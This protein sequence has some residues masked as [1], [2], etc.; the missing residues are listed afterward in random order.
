MPKG[1]PAKTG[2][3]PPTTTIM[4]T[5]GMNSSRREEEQQ[6]PRKRS[7][8]YDAERIS[9]DILAVY[10]NWVPGDPT[11]LLE[12][13]FLRCRSSSPS[14]D[15][16]LLQT[17]STV[18]AST[19]TTKTTV[20]RRGKAGGNNNNNNNKKT[21]VRRRGTAAA[22]GNIINN[23]RNAG[24]DIPEITSGVYA[25]FLDRHGQ[26]TEYFPH[27]MLRRLESE[28]LR[29]L[30]AYASSSA[31]SAPSLSLSSSTSSSSSSPP[32]SASSPASSLSS[33][34]EEHSCTSTITPSRAAVTQGGVGGGQVWLVCQTEK[35][36]YE[37]HF[38]HRPSAVSLST[39]IPIPSSSSDD[40]NSSIRFHGVHGSLDDANVKVME[41]F[42][43][44]HRGFMPTTSSN[45]PSY[46][47]SSK[48]TD[49]GFGYPG[50]NHGGGGGGG[51]DINNCLGFLEMDYQCG[52]G[53]NHDIRGD[54]DQHPGF[55]ERRPDGM[56]G[57]NTGV[58]N[59]D[60]EVDGA[61][62]WVD[63]GG[64]LSLRARNWGMGDSKI[65]VLRQDF[66]P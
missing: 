47:F 43:K 28:R 46:A 44:L 60:E 3:S 12:Q 13:G 45:Y 29:R 5:V 53:N 35:G 6:P 34:P 57:L 7:K 31:S 38:R 50:G 33:H 41:T 36:G 30:S 20:R 10:P 54:F 65:F 1:R 26:R 55:Q 62:W 42:Q 25:A 4:A 23:F 56:L 37:Q 8:I 52:G 49:M 63:G 39:S 51:G 18:S 21:P 11:V 9:T 64:C 27:A 2:P 32:L 15:I 48:K 17:D 19:S 16:A 59:G 14:R 66:S 24:H 40:D 22:V 58:E 61:S